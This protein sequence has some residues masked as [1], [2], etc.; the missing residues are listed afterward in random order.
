[1]AESSEPGRN[2]MSTAVKQHFFGVYKC[3]GSEG[4]WVS[5]RTERAFPSQ[6]DLSGGLPAARLQV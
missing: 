2:L 5:A 1:M 3:L 6:F 4:G